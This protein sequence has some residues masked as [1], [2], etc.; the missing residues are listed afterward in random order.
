MTPF[1]SASFPGWEVGLLMLST[2][3]L[4]LAIGSI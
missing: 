2:L 1:Q 4:G 3:A